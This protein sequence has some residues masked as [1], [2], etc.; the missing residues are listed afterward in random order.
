ME[1]VSAFS[2]YAEKHGNTKQLLSK[3]KK[4]RNLQEAYKQKSGKQKN[5][6]QTESANQQMGQKSTLNIF[7]RR[8]SLKRLFNNLNVIPC[9]L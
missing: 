4:K 7:V 3:K 9:L 2:V 1:Q 8:G 5:V 6:K